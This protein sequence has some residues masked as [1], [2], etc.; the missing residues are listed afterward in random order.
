MPVLCSAVL[1]F[2]R[3]LEMNPGRGRTRGSVP[4]SSSSTKRRAGS[5]H[6]CPCPRPAA[7]HSAL[8]ALPLSQ[9]QNLLPPQPNEWKGRVHLARNPRSSA[10]VGFGEV[11]GGNAGTVMGSCTLSFSAQTGRNLEQ[12]FHSGRMGYL[13]RNVHFK[14]QSSGEFRSALD[15][16]F[17]QIPIPAVTN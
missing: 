14:P 2:I 16:G 12:A 17:H 8:A 3:K 15:A 13:P 4:S 6:G 10:V 5:T 1:L 9:L 11:G 7:P